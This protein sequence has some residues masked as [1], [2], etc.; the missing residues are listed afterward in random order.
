MCY[1]FCERVIKR[2]ERRKDFHIEEDGNM[3][4]HIS[5]ELKRHILFTSFGALTG[6]LII[7]VSLKMPK[8][9]S[10][11]IFY[12]LKDG[13]LMKS[14]ENQQQQNNQFPIFKKLEERIMKTDQGTAI[15]IANNGNLV[16]S[17]C[18]RIYFNNIN[19]K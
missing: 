18:N 19:D 11:N 15:A 14:S 12:V 4:K 17:L 13:N 5:R 7:F 1:Q 10:Y 8:N 6:I 2:K 3:I 9:I 16:Y